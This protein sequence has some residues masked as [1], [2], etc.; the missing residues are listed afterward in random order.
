M[1]SENCEKKEETVIVK[2]SFL[3]LFLAKLQ[4][5]NRSSGFSSTRTTSDGRWHRNK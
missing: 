5:I 2:N 4:R 1:N 3:F